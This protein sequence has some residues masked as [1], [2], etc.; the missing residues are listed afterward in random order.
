M[1]MKWITGIAF[2]CLVVACMG[3]DQ[4]AKL[5]EANKAV[6]MGV[7][8][9]MNN[10]DYDKMSEFLAEDYIRHCQATPE[11]TV[12]SRDDFIALMKGFEGAFPDGRVR[13]DMLIAEGDLVALWGSYLGTHTGP[14]GDIPAT[15]KK[16]DSEMGGVHRLENGKIVE[17]WVTWDNLTML[18]QLGLY[19]PPAADTTMSEGK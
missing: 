6:V 3:C 12:K 16:I 8:E 18:S 2:L 4:Q 9:A 13:I 1:R 5:E 14:M 17:T 7:A 11:V 10:L 19:P 15:G